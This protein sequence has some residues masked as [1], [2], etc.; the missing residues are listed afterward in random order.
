MKVIIQRV[1]ESRVRVKDEIIGEIGKGMVLL[2]GIKNGDG[3]AQG[4]FLAEKCAHLRIFPDGE[5]KMNLSVL[6]TNGEV[7]VVSQFTLYG[8]TQKGRRPSFID[9]ARPEVA[10]PLYLKFMEQL[11]SQGIKKVVE[12]RFGAMMVVEIFN[13]GPVTLE[14]EAAGG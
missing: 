4:Q 10:E 1:I 13:D 11:R 9:A 14:L 5:G 2:L 7:L 12:G 3:E 8:D 6:E